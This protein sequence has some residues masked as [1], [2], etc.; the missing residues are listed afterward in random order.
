MH[1]IRPEVCSHS[2]RWFTGF[3]WPDWP[4]KI[5]RRWLGAGRRQYSKALAFFEE[6][7][8]FVNSNS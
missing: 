5:P 7:F 1:S 8:N 3:G 6:L 4:V 2:E